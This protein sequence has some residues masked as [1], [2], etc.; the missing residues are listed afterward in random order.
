MGEHVYVWR[1]NINTMS[2]HKYNKIS[3]CHIRF[4]AHSVEQDKGNQ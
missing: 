1:M 3:T 4:T 2:L